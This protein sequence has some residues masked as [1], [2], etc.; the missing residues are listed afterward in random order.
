MDKNNTT[1]A[2]LG[3]LTLVHNRGDVAVFSTDAF[4]M[5]PVDKGAAAKLPITKPI[6]HETNKWVRYG[7]NDTFP[8]EIANKLGKL[9]VAESALDFIS[10][11]HFGKGIRWFID[12][13][14]TTPGKEISII[15]KIADW[16]RLKKHENI[17]LILS[18]II[19]SLKRFGWAVPIFTFTND[20]HLN[21][22]KAIIKR[23]DCLDTTYCRF[24]PKD[25]TTG[26]IK[27]VL[28]SAKFGEMTPGEIDIDKYPIFDKNNPYKYKQFAFPISETNWGQ[29]Y[30]P[31]PSYY[32]VFRNKWADIAISVPDMLSNIYKH[33]MVLQY[34]VFMPIG[35]F[36]M[37]YKDWEDKSEEDQIKCFQAEQKAINDSLTNT[38]N[39]G[40]TIISITGTDKNG[41]ANEGIKIEPIKDFLDN[42]KD[43]LN[44][45]NATLEILIAMGVDPTLA[46]IAIPGTNNLS[47]SGSD[48]RMG[49][50]IKQATM[51]R[52]R[53]VTLQVPN[54]I[55]IINKYPDDVYPAYINLDVSQTLDVNPTASQTTKQ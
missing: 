49:M 37:K 47:G 27:E 34:H 29:L 41:N 50:Q 26:I 33:M 5:N 55:S 14:T 16:N 44:N 10:D 19:A 3:S 31:Y 51:T 52:E 35:Y 42:K 54:L 28:Y 43:L 15:Q 30:Y 6:L 22:E 38:N 4:G 53:L 1:I 11:V 18:D 7:D 45:S 23:V 36:I 9:G 24:P 12:D 46:G 13:V 25:E 8:I 21:P 32:P 48:K 2:G 17:E 20:W 39:S 40:K